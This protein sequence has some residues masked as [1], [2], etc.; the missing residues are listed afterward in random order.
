M[1]LTGQSEQNFL[2]SWASSLAKNLVTGIS[3]NRHF[4]SSHQSGAATNGSLI[5]QALD[6]RSPKQQF[7][8]HRNLQTLLLST[9]RRS[10]AKPPQLALVET[11]HSRLQVHLTCQS[12]QTLLR[13]RS[14]CCSC[15]DSRTNSTGDINDRRT[16]RQHNVF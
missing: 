14:L 13:L 5:H 11:S 7:E 4:A 16:F 2:I 1:Y 9:I 3:A 8:G 10:R 12:R 6:L 15:L